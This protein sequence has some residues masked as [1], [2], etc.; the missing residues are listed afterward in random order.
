METNFRL[1]GM[2]GLFRP[3]GAGG[4]R[5]RCVLMGIGRNPILRRNPKSP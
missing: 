1:S 3:F 2:E 4:L 5:I